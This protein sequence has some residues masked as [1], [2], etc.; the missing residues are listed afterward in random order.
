MLNLPEFSDK[1]LFGPDSVMWKLN[2]EQ[3]IL[4]GGPAAAVLQIA[5]PK[6]ARGVADHSDFRHDSYGRFK[7]TLS[8]IR[9]IT[10]GSRDEVLKMAHG[11]QRMHKRVQAGPHAPG[12]PYSAFDPD[13]Q[14]WV[15]ATLIQGAVSNY[16]LFIGP[17]TPEEKQAYLEDM[18]LWGEFFGLPRTHGPNTWAAFQDYFNT[19]LHGPLLGSEPVCAEVAQRVVH[20]ERPHLFRLATSPLRFLVTERIPQPLLERL[21]LSSSSWTRAGWSAAQTLVPALYPHLPKRWRFPIEYH[22]A[23]PRWQTA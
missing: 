21:G 4:L 8:A 2:R 17:L 1:G 20:L 9:T 5:H 14:L 12:G 18:K 10:F 15:L 16:E 7:R 6:V 3:A 23:L 22:R 11:V 19:M 13:L